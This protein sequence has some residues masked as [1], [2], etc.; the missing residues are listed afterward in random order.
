M[1]NAQQSRVFC[2]EFSPNSEF[3]VTTSEDK[4]AK[5]WDAKSGQL[6]SAFA[7]HV[8]F[9]A[10]PCWSPDGSRIATTCWFP[11]GVVRIWDPMTGEEK[12]VFSKHEIGFTV[13]VNFSPDGS[14]AAST[15]L[16]GDVLIW[17]PETGEL[18]ISLYPSENR[19]RVWA[20]AW[21]PDGERIATHAQD[22]IF[23]VW[24]SHTGEE[25]FAT[26]G[27]SALLFTMD[28]L[29]S[30]DRIFSGD[31][32]GVFK[33]F[34]ACNGAQVFS[35]KIEKYANMTLS[36]DGTRFATAS[37]PGGPIKIFSLWDSLE[38]LIEYA[39]ENCLI[40]ELAPMEREQFGLPE[41]Q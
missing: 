24:N 9:P 34:D 20:V 21:S 12:L 22:G 35:A 14:C 18:Q 26:P 10:S 27:H 5:V 25:L 15:S 29:P 32:N 7:G 17:D 1:L 30:G 23:R 36:P 28:W 6:I 31:Q 41:V 11:E 8:G 16:A 39:H 40:R 19:F 3:I 37:S 13:R 33:M 2:A 38:E 4:E